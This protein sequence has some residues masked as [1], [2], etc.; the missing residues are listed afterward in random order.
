MRFHQEQL[1][2]VA[3]RDL[4]E[5]DDVLMT[6]HALSSVAEAVLEA[7]IAQ[8]RPEVS[9]CI[10][11]LGMT[12]LGLLAFAAMAGGDRQRSRSTVAA[13]IRRSSTV[14]PSSAMPRTTSYIGES[15]C[16]MGRHS[17]RF[18][19]RARERRSLCAPPTTGFGR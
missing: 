10:V 11:G 17:R 12:S 19:D 13:P 14:M 8:V 4:L 1:V 7:A 9:F 15:L 16:L 6:A 18:A 3:T 5:M 2:R